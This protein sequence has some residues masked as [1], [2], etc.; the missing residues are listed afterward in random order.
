MLRVAP[1]PH[2]LGMKA[3]YLDGEKQM[4]LVL[5][6]RLATVNLCFA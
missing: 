4:L 6:Y 5:L 3:S 1:I 2:R